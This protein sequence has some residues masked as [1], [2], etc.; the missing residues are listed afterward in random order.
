MKDNRGSI[1]I[2]I[3]L[4]LLA[5]LS[6][7]LLLIDG[8]RIIYGSAKIKQT[9]VGANEHILANYHRE[10]QERYHLFLLDPGFIVERGIS[11]EIQTYLENSICDSKQAN[12]LYPFEIE[13]ISIVREVYPDE[14]DFASIK[15]QIREYMKYQQTAEWTSEL[16]EKM[17]TLKDKDSKENET[18]SLLDQ[19]QRDMESQLEEEAQKETK[20]QEGAD[21]GKMSEEGLG[22]GNFNETGE[23]NPTQI[24]QE[25]PRKVV[26]DIMNEGILRVVLPSGKS[27]SSRK[28]SGNSLP[29]EEIKKIQEQNGTMP[30]IDFLALDKIKTLFVDSNISKAINEMS[31]EAVNIAYCMD[32][33]SNFSKKT[34]NKQATKLNYEVEY[35]LHGGKTDKENLENIV[36]RILLFRFG[37]NFTYALTDASLNAQALS[38]A[39]AIAGVTGL[40][41]I[42]TA[43]K[44]MILAAVSYAESVLDVRSLLAGNK[45]PILKNAWNWTISIENIGSILSSKTT[46]AN[47]E[48]G[49]NYEDFLKIFLLSQTDSDAKYGRMLDLMQENIREKD[50]SFAIMEAIFGYEVYCEIKLSTLFGNGSKIFKVNRSCSY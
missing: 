27:L 47:D 19:Q 40:P 7:T 36:N 18:K 22:G 48:N 1:S 30:A 24:V 13:T 21:S 32:S 45:I 8:V 25:D 34:D 15:H 43:L 14:E 2:F 31:T 49:M 11:K 28:I 3:A 41:A 12:T 9:I 44:T 16:M 5:I 33:F 50:K 38:I 37:T 42:I 6:S 26:M 17:T 46:V 23:E 10:L 20:S 4:I 39:A 35:I 29:S